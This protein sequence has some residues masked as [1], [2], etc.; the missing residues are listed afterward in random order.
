MPDYNYGIF[1]KKKINYK[2]HL[3][4]LNPRPF[5]QPKVEQATKIGIIQLM[6]PSI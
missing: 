5:T 6:T 2:T 3:A 1:M 4:P